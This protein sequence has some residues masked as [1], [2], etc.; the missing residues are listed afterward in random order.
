[1][2]EPTVPRGV[3]GRVV[4]LA[5]FALV[6]VM[7]GGLWIVLDANR[8]ELLAQ[9]AGAK[10]SFAV[11]S[12]G[13]Y[14]V[15]LMSDDGP[16]PFVLEIP[17]DESLPGRIRN[18]EEYIEVV[19]QRYADGALLL[20]FPH[21]DSRV[22]LSPVS[23]GLF[24]GVY[25]KVR[26]ATQIAEMVVTAERIGVVE[27]GV[28]ERFMG[29]DVP[30]GSVA[31]HWRMDFADDPDAL[32]IFEQH[33]DGTLSGTIV[34]S[35]G[36]YRYLAGEVFGSSMSLSVFDGSHAFLFTADVDASGERLIDGV[37]NSGG[38]YRDT[39]TA[40]RIAED[41]PFE[42]LNA[43]DAVTLQPGVTKLSLPQL[44]ETPYEGAPT[45]VVAFGTWCPNCHDEAPMLKAMYDKYHEQG[46][47]IL[48]L[49]FERSDDYERSMRQIERFKERYGIS[50]NIIPVGDTDKARAAA[51]LPDLSDFASYP[52]TIFV[53]RDRSVEAILSGYAGPATGERHARLMEEFDKHLAAIMER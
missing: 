24:M 11:A 3:S 13:W 43:F 39:F 28:G 50:W 49:A 10:Q 32:G 21:Y 5:F 1:M 41:D 7:G 37:F 42:P 8:D 6:A 9:R 36:D 19:L 53:R 31:G 22:T 29:G 25:Y 45:L 18:G 35:T 2:Q 47:E 4:L 40:R 15:T 38:Y 26:S 33:E 30:T 14:R 27:P 12:S 52:T 51:A 48:G 23:N 46:L 20:D 34:T 44:R 17:A 16:M